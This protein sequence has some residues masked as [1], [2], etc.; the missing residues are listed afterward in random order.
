MSAAQ[1]CLLLSPELDLPLCQKGIGAV[2]HTPDD[3][4]L[5]DGVHIEC[6]AIHPDDRGYF[7]ELVRSGQGLV[8]SYP[9][10]GMQVSASV[11]HPG[12]IKAFHY[13]VR[14]TDCWIP[15]AGMLQV[16]L[17]DLRR[18]APTFGIRNTL[19]LGIL[20]PWRLRIPP[21]VAHGYKVIGPDPA[22]LV[23]VT[24]RFYD[25]ADEGRIPYNHSAINYDWEIQYK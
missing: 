14:Q 1:T 6:S 13:H 20:R 21:G 9:P 11:S 12:I 17:V 8:A 19:Y 25:P 22:V 2:I 4:A 7:M 3:A 24:D 16:A 15:V 18:A 5:I 10:S 23:Y